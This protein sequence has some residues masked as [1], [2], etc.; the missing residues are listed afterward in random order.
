MR[1]AQNEGADTRGAHLGEIDGD[2]LWLP[3]DSEALHVEVADRS[4]HR[5]RPARERG[6]GEIITAF[7]GIRADEVWRTAARSQALRATR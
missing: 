6:V 3:R 5:E 1:D 4:R 2:D 7:N